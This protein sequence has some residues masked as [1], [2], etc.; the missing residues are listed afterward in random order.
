MAR[1]FIGNPGFKG[2]TPKTIGILDNAR[3]Y[4]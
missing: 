2:E 1:V 4:N 3:T